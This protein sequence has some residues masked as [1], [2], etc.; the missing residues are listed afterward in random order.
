MSIDWLLWSRL[1][2][3]LLCSLVVEIILSG[4]RVKRTDSKYN[5][6]S[7][8]I[9]IVIKKLIRNLNQTEVNYLNWNYFTW[10]LRDQ[11]NQY[12]LHVEKRRSQS[13]FLRCCRCRN[14]QFSLWLTSSQ[15]TQNFD[16]VK[17]WVDTRQCKLQR[18]ILKLSYILFWFS[19]I[20][21]R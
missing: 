20:W 17:F 4:F 12:F 18:W 10:A 6:F 7:R 1:Y 9:S 11:W 19:T 5:V 21:G 16:I 3:T 8:N 13:Q 2:Y 14:V 15:L